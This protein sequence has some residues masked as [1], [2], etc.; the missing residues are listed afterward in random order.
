VA[1]VVVFWLVG[2]EE[3]TDAQPRGCG[4]A[5]SAEARLPEVQR[6]R[7]W[8]T[9]RLAEFVGRGDR[10][11]FRRVPSRRDP[12][13][14]PASATSRSG[15]RIHARWRDLLF[16]F[17]RDE[18]VLGSSGGINGYILSGDPGAGPRPAPSSAPS[19]RRV[20]R[21][22]NLVMVYLPSR[23]SGADAPAGSVRGSDCVGGGV[24]ARQ[25]KVPQ[26]TVAMLQMQSVLPQLLFH[27]LQSHRPMS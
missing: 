5:I 12:R 23:V 21:R 4:P 26:R 16:G 19:W 3:D 2:R 17:V 15:K 8:Q 1:V 7:V 10:R 27:L 24:A 14:T 13:L 18:L 25:G 11:P 9:L 22:P 6:N 20:S